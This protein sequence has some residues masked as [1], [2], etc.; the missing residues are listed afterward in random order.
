MAKVRPVSEDGAGTTGM[1]VF[2]KACGCGHLF[3][4][5]PGPNGVGGSKP[6]W[7]FD[8]NMDAPTFSPSMLCRT[9]RF[10]ARGEADHAAWLD[11]G[12]PPPAPRFESEPLVCHS[13]VRAGTMEYLP[14]CSHELASQTVDLPDF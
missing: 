13:F 1:M 6:V 2:C 5:A 8:G 9:T 11:A 3:N 7:T 12:C 10:T 4:T 14:D